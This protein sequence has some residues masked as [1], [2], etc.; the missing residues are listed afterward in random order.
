MGGTKISGEVWILVAF[1]MLFTGLVILRGYYK[2]WYEIG[3]F[4]LRKL[5]G[6]ET[7]E[8]IGAF[9]V[10]GSVLIFAVF[11]LFL[12]Q[13]VRQVY[14]SLSEAFIVIM[15]IIAFTIILS[16]IYGLIR[17]YLDFAKRNDTNVDNVEQHD[18]GSFANKIVK[19]LEIK[20]IKSKT[21]H[22]MYHSLIGMIAIL[23]ALV[24]I[25]I[26]KS[27]NAAE[28]FNNLP[29]LLTL[30]AVTLALKSLFIAESNYSHWVQILYSESPRLA[31][32]EL[33]KESSHTKQL[34][35]SLWKWILLGALGMVVVLI[36]SWYVN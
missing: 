19:Y 31:R 2:C 8:I 30:I 9:F 15:T 26:I 21:F 32:K 6:R 28:S 18:R 12:Q 35:K 17:P 23:P 1:I 27:S 14:K 25:G 22:A 11:C 36:V 4:V 16:A 13:G 33:A 7:D 5:S 34:G 3:S 29:L 24:I 20:R 10:I